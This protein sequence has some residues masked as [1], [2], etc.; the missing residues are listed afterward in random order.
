M[1]PGQRASVAHTEVGRTWSSE[2]RRWER[3]KYRTGNACARRS[4]SPTQVNAF[5]QEQAVCA[6]E[7]RKCC[8]CRLRGSNP[9]APDGVGV[10]AT[11][12]LR[13][14]VERSTGAAEYLASVVAVPWLQPSNQCGGK[15]LRGTT[16]GYLTSWWSGKESG[17]LLDPVAFLLFRSVTAIIFLKQERFR[18]I[19]EINVATERTEARRCHNST[20]K[21]NRLKQSSQSNRLCGNSANVFERMAV[22]LRLS[23]YAIPY[24]PTTSAWYVTGEWWCGNWCMARSVPF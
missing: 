21:A 24:C 8:V 15:S 1:R 11:T 18:R 17:M 19:G 9:L 7:A 23:S 4:I 13:P 16:G 10:T 14:V 20:L 12:F 2:L 6:T 3:P 5:G 22:P